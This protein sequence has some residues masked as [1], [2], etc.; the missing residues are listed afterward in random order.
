MYFDSLRGKQ[1]VY[2][3]KD[4]YFFTERGILFRFYKNEEGQQLV[5]ISDGIRSEIL[6][7]D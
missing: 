5:E 2:W 7:K 4:N 6:I 3:L 1:F